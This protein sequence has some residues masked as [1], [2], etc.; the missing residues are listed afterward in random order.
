MGQPRGSQSRGRFPRRRE[1]LQ[2]LQDVDQV[3]Q[4]GSDA[5]QGMD[6]QAAETK[7]YGW[8]GRPPGV[9]TSA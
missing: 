3:R 4:A 1:R 6:Y 7:S 8:G 9:L 2:I 5:T